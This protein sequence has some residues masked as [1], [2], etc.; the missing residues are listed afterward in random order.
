MIKFHKRIYRRIGMYMVFLLLMA[1]TVGGLSQL[2]AYFNTGADQSYK[3]LVRKALQEHTPTF[4]WRYSSESMPGFLDTFVRADVQEAYTNAWHVANMSFLKKNTQTLGDFFADTIEAHIIDLIKSQ[5][6][7]EVHRADLNHQLDVHLFSLDRQLLSFTDRD[8]EIRK[9]VLNSAT[10]RL[11]AQSR[12]FA[13]FD[14]VMTLDDGQWRI[15]HFR[16]TRAAALPHS[17]DSFPSRDTTFFTVRDGALYKG[18]SLFTVRGVNYY[19]AYSPWMK[20]WETFDSDTLRRDFERIRAL[21]LNTL[22]V[23]IPYAGFG[24]GQVFESMLVRLDTLVEMARE[25]QLALVITLFD[26]PEGFTLQYYSATDRQLE[27]ILRRYADESHILAWDLKNEADRDFP[28]HGKKTVLDWLEFMAQRAHQYAPRQM[29]T[30]GWSKA[31]FAAILQDQV[32]FISF[33]YYEHPS[34]LQAT[35]DTMRMEV[36]N[37]LLMVQETGLPTASIPLLPGGGSEEEQAQYY[38]EVLRILEKN[39]EIPFFIWSL[40]DFVEAPK[41]VFGWKPWIRH[42]QKHFGILTVDGAEKPAAKVI[43]PKMKE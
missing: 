3:V 26:F 22:R 43:M 29:I 38:R 31:E 16:K 14:V 35:L 8:V 17:A 2:I 32:D 18:D 25:Y 11:V 19:P 34:L 33:H 39:G 12:E 23:F 20:F 1:L 5:E 40:Y 10:G 7:L 9:K 15:R 36:G 42:F 41:E 4:V 21:E 27:T 6:D 28:L 24:K 13:D 37:K 30:I